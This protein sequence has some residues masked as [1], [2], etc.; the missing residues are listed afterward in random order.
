MKQIRVLLIED[1]FL[2]R[3][4]LHS[5]LSGHAQIAVIG[6]A[7]DGELGIAM[8]REHRPDVVVLD[9]RLPRVSGFDVIIALRKDFPTAKIVILSNY[10]GS[11][12]IYRAV[13]SGAMA[14]LTKDASGEELL[15]AIQSVHRGLR[16]LPHVALDR[17]AERTPAVDLTPRESEVLVCITQGRSNQEIADE[18]GIA[19]KTVRIH[20]SSL[21]DKMGARDRTQATIY[22]LQRGLVH[23]D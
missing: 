14:Y 11:E 17:L 4:A 18:L 6:E 2:A 20:V 9:L 15:N 23:F 16:Y 5:V 12:D 3:M 7:S 8:Y 22:A 13:R 10:Q 19:E 1:H 21:L